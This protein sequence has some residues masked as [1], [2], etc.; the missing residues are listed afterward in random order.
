M[1]AVVVMETI[2]PTSTILVFIAFLASCARL[3][4]VMSLL[5]RTCVRE[6]YAWRNF[7]SS[8]RCANQVRRMLPPAIRQGISRHS[9]TVVPSSIGSRLRA[10]R[11]IR[12]LSLPD[13]SESTKIP[14]SLLEALERDD[15]RR[16]PKGQLYRR[17]FFRSYLEVLGLPAEPLTSEFARLSPGD[18]ESVPPP[19]AVV[20]R[21]PR[22][23]VASAWRPGL[24]KQIASIRAAVRRS[25]PKVPVFVG[26]LVE[27]ALVVAVGALVASLT[28]MVPLAGIGVVAMVFYPATRS[29]TGQS[30]GVV[31]A[32]QRSGRALGRSATIVRRRSARTLTAMNY[33]FWSA[34]RA[35]AAAAQV[36]A[37]RRLNRTTEGG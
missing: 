34:V 6:Y 30:R 35:A 31:P 20:S 4:E 11:E 19:A 22:A 12:G 32:L 15:L 10:E 37:A 2:D 13:V 1:K 36:L 23:R 33:G 16:W 3:V 25:R 29:A 24:A 21:P 26:A 18:G 28:N 8:L 17:A 14:V 27:A 7:L 9:V 5:L